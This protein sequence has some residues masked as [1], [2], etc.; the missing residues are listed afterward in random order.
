MSLLTIPTYSSNIIPDTITDG[1]TNVSNLTYTTYINKVGGADI[2]ASL[3]SGYQKGQLKYLFCTVNTA[4]TTIITP[5]I[6][7]DGTTLTFNAPGDSA[8]LLWLGDA[9][10]IM[11]ENGVVIA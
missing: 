3:D 9:W 2:N 11:E 4:N 6:L 1:D 10:K 8:L 7:Y 5:N